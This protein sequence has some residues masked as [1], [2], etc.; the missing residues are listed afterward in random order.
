MFGIS[1]V[2]ICNKFNSVEIRFRLDSKTQDNMVFTV[3]IYFNHKNH[4]PTNK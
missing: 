4:I 3:K 1:K 2:T